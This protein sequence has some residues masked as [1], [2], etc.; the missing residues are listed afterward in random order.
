[1][2]LYK[3]QQEHY[4]LIIVLSLPR[5]YYWNRYTSHKAT[6]VKHNTIFSH[7]DFRVPTFNIIM[8][9][10]FIFKQVISQVR[11]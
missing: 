10:F 9:C 1:M 4:K 5:E 7:L 3:L 6:M 2:Y 11:K 8:Q